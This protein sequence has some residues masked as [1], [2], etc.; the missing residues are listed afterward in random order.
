MNWNQGLQW[1]KRIAVVLAGLAISAAIF[2]WSE[3]SPAQ[4]GF[5]SRIQA[6]IGIAP[7][8]QPTGRS[9]GGA[10]RGPICVAAKGNADRLNSI[11]ALVPVKAEANDPA[12]DPASGERPRRPRIEGVKPKE[13]VGS[14]TVAAN[15]TFWFYL[16][17]IL[18]DETPQNRVAQFV[19]LDKNDRPVWNELM[20]V[21]LLPTPRLLEYKLPFSLQQGEDGVYSWYFS[22]VCDTE[23]LSR[24]PVVR[25]W[26][27]R[28]DRTPA[29]QAALSSAPRFAQYQ[30]YA[31]AGLWFDTV[32]SLVKTRRQFPST[33]RD[34]WTTLL[35]YFQIPE[36]NQLDGLEATAPADREAVSGNQLPARI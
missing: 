22:V 29:L 4:T 12:N 18:T 28:I 15:P 24:N 5:W 30:A 6:L 20:N 8:S 32:D 21:E 25:G 13:F 16:P 23:K 7:A 14:Y 19:L 26:V 9:A 10:G 2:L 1:K 27:A 11:L 34:A 35:E 3:P 17:Y 33:N 36:A 31:E